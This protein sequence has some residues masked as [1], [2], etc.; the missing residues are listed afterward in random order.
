MKLRERG[1]IFSGMLYDGDWHIRLT[2]W[3]AMAKDDTKSAEIRAAIVT[4]EELLQKNDECVHTITVRIP[5]PTGID[6]ALIVS[7]LK[8]APC[9]AD[10]VE[11]EED[12]IIA[13]TITQRGNWDHA[14]HVA[15]CCIKGTM[16]EVI[17]SARKADILRLSTHLGGLPPLGSCP[18]Q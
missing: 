4:L 12:D 11:Y 13:V 7:S 6:P 14:H 9:S 1:G 18:N 3:L 8:E 16:R 2:R 17:W 15:E 5:M 10:S